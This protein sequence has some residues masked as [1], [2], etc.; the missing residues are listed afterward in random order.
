MKFEKLHEAI[1]AR[2]RSNIK[3]PIKKAVQKAKPVDE[4]LKFDLEQVKN[5]AQQVESWW[6]NVVGDRGYE[7][8]KEYEESPSSFFLTPKYKYLLH[9]I[10]KERGEFDYI[11]AG[12]ILADQLHD[13]PEEMAD[14]LPD[15]IFDLAGSDRDLANDVAKILSKNG[16]SWEA[17]MDDFTGK[18]K[19]KY[20]KYKPVLSKAEQ[21]RKRAADKKKK[22]ADKIAA[23][24]DAPKEFGR[25]NKFSSIAKKSDKQ[26]KANDGHIYGM[27]KGKWYR[28]VEDKTFTD[29]ANKVLS[30]NNDED[31]PSVVKTD[32]DLFLKKHK[33]EFKNI[34][35]A[36]KILKNL[37][38]EDDDIKIINLVGK[39]FGLLENPDVHEEF[40][41]K[42]M[43]LL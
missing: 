13:D 21:E 23:M 12:E 16:K 24:A 43:G 18:K 35:T 3:K 9:K 30:E 1:T 20:K 36:K 39:F 4:P 8:A 5:I 37:A 7:L 14:M 17:A 11:I 38:N 41:N 29:I 40:I 22:A 27:V 19:L 33:D 6:A 31:V 42:I 34:P 2:K 25:I 15:K 32:L 26:Y 28:L 10:E